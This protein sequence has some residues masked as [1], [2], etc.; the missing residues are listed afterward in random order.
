MHRARGSV[1]PERHAERQ[2]EEDA[3]R[4]LRRTIDDRGEEA[5]KGRGGG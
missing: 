1:P 5:G 2:G 4:V 3:R